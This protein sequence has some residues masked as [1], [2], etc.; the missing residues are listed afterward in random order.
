MTDKQKRQ[1]KKK[2]SV[3]DW[4]AAVYATE[5]NLDTM[6][7]FLLVTIH[8]FLGPDGMGAFPSVSRLSRMMKCTERTVYNCLNKAEEAGF[9]ER[10]K[11]GFRGQRK[12]QNEYTAR[13][14]DT[15]HAG[16][17]TEAIEEKEEKVPVTEPDSGVNQ[18]HP[19]GPKNGLRGELDSPLPLNQIHP[20]RPSNRPLK[21]KE[22]NFIKKE[23]S[24]SEEEITD[25]Y[26]EFILAYPR[27][28]GVLAIDTDTPRVRERFA[29]AMHA[30]GGAGDLLKATENYA[31][32]MN[33]E[34]A[35]DQSKEI[36]IKNPEGFLTESYYKSFLNGGKVRAGQKIPAAPLRGSRGT[37]N[38]AYV[39]WQEYAKE[40]R[41]TVE[42]LKTVEALPEVGER[43]LESGG[44]IWG[45]VGAGKTTVLKEAAERR[46]G[47]CF[48]NWTQFYAEQLERQKNPPPE[49]IYS[50]E[51][52]NALLA[53]RPVLVIDEVGLKAASAAEV[54][55]L[56]RIVDA[57]LQGGRK[58]VLV[59]NY[60]PSEL[61]KDT[62]IGGQVF[63]RVTTGGLVVLCP[64]KSLRGT[65][66]KNNA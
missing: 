3:W 44:I 65:K 46:G 20:Y 45:E 56:Y 4:R 32:K 16:S 28:Q 26:H 34:M 33:G 62:G 2:T 30:D 17:P 7:T 9:I 11:H 6:T 35:E 13:L 21:E 41:L 64:W 1:E 52:I 43:L 5:S 58:T 10:G 66:R 55:M 49:K 54:A 42:D 8:T 38:A 27:G 22:K 47:Y 59:T 19:S 15:F 31:E 36:F 23:N 18:I 48:I 53:T 37:G 29:L 25:A 51:S 57:R 61:L 50:A 24:F 63:D 39:E 14:P 12:D 40:E 60:G